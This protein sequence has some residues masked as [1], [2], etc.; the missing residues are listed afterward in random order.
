[1]AD[2]DLLVRVSRLYYELGETQ[3]RIAEL[4]GV[5]RSGVSRLLKQA[6][7]EGI[8]E[9]RIIDR[10]HEESPVADELAAR[11]GLRAV[12]LAPSLAGPEDL[13]RR[14]VGRLAAQVLRD[15]VRNGMVI[16]VGEGAAV[17][18]TIDAL[19][20]A[21]T[22]VA[23]TVVPLSGGGWFMSPASDPV[24]R[25]ADALGGFAQELPAPGIV[26]NPLTKAAL[27]GHSGVQ[28][29]VRLWQQLDIALFGIG[30]RS[31]GEAWFGAEAI[32]EIEEARAVG[33]MLIAPFDLD[34]NFV[35][36]G[37]SERTIGFDARDLGRIPTS[38]AVA[39]GTTK[40]APVLGA[41]RTGVIAILV[42]DLDTGRRV[43]ELDERTRQHEVAADA[44]DAAPAV[45]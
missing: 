43:L 18:A 14:M 36:P 17:S 28:N 38:I 19:S 13:T 1:M 41:L 8:V 23:A 3:E 7:A 27:L 25:L 21:V 12:H 16:G 10:A 33:E 9:I 42:T 20:D 29:I 39:G 2:F 22:P 31:W 34:G 15:V 5:T 26:N 30:V 4:V 24:R 32:K 11:F 6:R 37:L 44:A 35:S 40:V 45:R